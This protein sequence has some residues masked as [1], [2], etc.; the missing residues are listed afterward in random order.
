MYYTVVFILHFVQ[1]PERFTGLSVGPTPR[2]DKIG[3]MLN[4]L[5]SVIHSH[6]NS[7]P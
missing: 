2:F 5:V 4:S 7:K 3:R 6:P 1:M